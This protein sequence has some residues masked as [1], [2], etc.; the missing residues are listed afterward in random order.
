[1]LANKPRLKLLSSMFS[2]RSSLKGITQMCLHIYIH[3]FTHL[4]ENASEW[5]FISRREGGTYLM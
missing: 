4:H 2:E 5:A 1:M 3:T